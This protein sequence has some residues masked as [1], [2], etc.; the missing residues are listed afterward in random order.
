M[1]ILAIV[2]FGIALLGAVLGVLN[3][4]RNFDRD[5]VKLII[6]PAHSILVGGAEHLWPGIDFCIEVVNLSAFP[7]T[8]QEIGFENRDMNKR[9]VVVRSLTVDGGSLPRRLETREAVSLYFR[10]PGADERHLVKHAYA[11]TACGSKFTGTSP[12]LKQI[13]A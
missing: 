7:V 5:R 13:S 11:K 6:K 3:T 1:D 10:K 2:T 9:A 12:A 8:V 4:W